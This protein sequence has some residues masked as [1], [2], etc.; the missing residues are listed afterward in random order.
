MT[1][2][3]TVAGSVLKNPLDIEE[4]VA[5]T[6]LKAWDA[7]PLYRPQHLRLFLG[8]IT[9]NLALSMWRKNSAYSRGGDQVTLAL[10]ELGE[11]IS[12]SDSPEEYV[13][14]QELE[15]SISAFLKTEKPIRRAVFLRRYF[16]LETI[17]S[18]AK[19][20]S[21]REANVRMMLTR[22]RQKLKKFLEQE[23]YI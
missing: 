22:V 5:D 12:N 13:N 11:C 20:Y 2:C 4:V 18:I 19:R 9:R 21:L 6:W 1:A 17:S 15:K 10:E 14:M 7:I 23:E 3:R 8:K 16:Y